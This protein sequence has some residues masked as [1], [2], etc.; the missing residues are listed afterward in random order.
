M[1]APEL[2]RSSGADVVAWSDGDGP[3]AAIARVLD[4]V[5]RL[6]VGAALPTGVA[7]ALTRRAARASSSRSTPGILAGLRERK[8]PD[9]LEHLRAAG[10][11]ADDAAAWIAGRR[12]PASPSARSRSS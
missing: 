7:F 6:L 3:E 2:A 12:S 11:H 4:G 10:R 9:E 5:G 1:L 8:R